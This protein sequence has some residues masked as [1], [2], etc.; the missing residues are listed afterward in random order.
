MSNFSSLQ[1]YIIYF[2]WNRRL[3]AHIQ[4]TQILSFD[5]DVPTATKRFENP[6]LAMPGYLRKSGEGT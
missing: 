3:K 2:S 5:S 1:R 6:Y 4:L